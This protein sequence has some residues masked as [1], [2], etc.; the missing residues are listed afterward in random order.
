MVGGQNYEEDVF[1]EDMEMT[2]LIEYVSHDDSDASHDT[3]FE[4]NY[5]AD[6][7]NSETNYTSIFDQQYQSDSDN[8]IKVDSHDVI[9]SESDTDC[10]NSEGDEEKDKINGINADMS[11]DGEDIGDQYHDFDKNHPLYHSHHATCLSE[12]DSLIPDFIGGSLPR[13][14]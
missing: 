5:N 4:T 13:S 14:D 8:T 7:A 11:D 2:D 10:I 6:Q 9:M 12:S 3:L 1:N